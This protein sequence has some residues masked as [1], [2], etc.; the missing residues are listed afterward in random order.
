MRLGLGQLSMLAGTKCQR[1]LEKGPHFE[2]RATCS[3]VVVTSNFQ[4]PTLQAEL[5]AAA[6]E[7]HIH[8]S[9]G[10]GCGVVLNKEEVLIGPEV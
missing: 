1:P 8:T 6:A 5:A 2:H 7:M 4:R 3:H 9:G 10:K